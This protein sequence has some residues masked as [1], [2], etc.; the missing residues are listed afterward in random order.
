MCET[1]H[2]GIKW[3]W[4]TLL[5]DGEVAVDMRVPAGREKLLRK[6]ARMVLL[7]AMGSKA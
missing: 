4:R 3:Q 7:E 2:L 6:Q 5:L 1:R